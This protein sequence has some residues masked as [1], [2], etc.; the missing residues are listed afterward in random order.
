MKKLHADQFEITLD[1]VAKLVETQFP[2]YAH[3]PIK[4]F[5]SIGTV[6]A[7]FRLG[8]D[9]HI[10]LP[11]IP[12]YESAILKEF[13][14]LSHLS[15]KLTTPIPKPIAL[16]TPCASFPCHWAIHSWIDGAH[17]D[18]HA[19]TDTKHIVREL[20]QFITEL[21]HLGVSEKAPKAGRKPLLTLNDQTIEALSD[22]APEID[23]DKALKAWKELV[24]TPAWDGK[25]VWIHADLLRPNLITHSTHL[26]GVI[27]FGSAGVGDPA[28]DFVAA[29]AVFDEASRS[30][31][32][33]LSDVDET[34]WQR[35]C[36][37]ALHQAALIIPYY[38][39]SNPA[40]TQ[41]AVATVQE[42]LKD[43]AAAHMV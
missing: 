18:A 11:L 35:A 15:N 17:F 26:K 25:P 20:A 22:S 27:D 42:I 10:R 14:I 2:A 29:W 38:R 39:E 41:T 40:F 37:Y 8:D 16:G 19:V 23:V 24:L 28:F 13:D 30:D 9:Y 1:L 34:V 31:F 36:A 43:L 6:N 21:H 33:R 3:L 4:K 12:A 7:I 5:D 32:K